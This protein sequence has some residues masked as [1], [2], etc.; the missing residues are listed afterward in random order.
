MNDYINISDLVIHHEYFV[1]EVKPKMKLT[2]YY[3]NGKTYTASGVTK[4]TETS[5]NLQYTQKKKQ[6]NFRVES[7]YTLDLVDVIAYKV[8]NGKE[9]KIIKLKPCAFVDTVVGVKKRDGKVLF[10]DSPL[11]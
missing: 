9:T 6:D 3:D 10:D 8:Q 2:V 1:K 7:V 5:V 11:N 4:Y